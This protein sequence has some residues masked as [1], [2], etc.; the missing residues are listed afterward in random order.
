LRVVNVNF[1][2]PGILGFIAQLGGGGVFI[3]LHFFLHIV[4]CPAVQLQSSADR[5][6]DINRA[7]FWLPLMLV[8]HTVPIF[9][10]YLSSDFEARHY[11]TWAW[12]LFSVRVSLGYYAM[13]ALSRVVPSSLKNLGKRMSYHTALRIILGPFIAIS[14]AVWINLL[15]NCPYSF[16]TLFS[17]ITSGP[18]IG[19]RW[20][21]MM[22]RCLQ[23][24]ELV[25]FG[26]AFVWLLFMGVDARTAKMWSQSQT[27][28]FA[29]MLVLIPA[30]GP[31]A[32]SG[33]MWLRRERALVEEKVIKKRN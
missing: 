10:M 16:S 29:A 33:V 27:L 5:R 15:I 8:F 28:G 21:G 1:R 26:S 9:G 2:S 22:R 6:I 12:Q 18:E 32:T 7:F 24:D 13:L 14:A 19:S 4:F 30:I 20:V 17:P 23:Y 25:V 11:W 31:G 3:P